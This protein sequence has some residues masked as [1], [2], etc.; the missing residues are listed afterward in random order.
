MD[1]SRLYAILD[2]D[3]DARRKLRETDK[4]I[5][6]CGM[7]KEQAD[8]AHEICILSATLKNPEAFKLVSDEVWKINQGRANQ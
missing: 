3:P 6:D 1:M 4:V 2:S 8:I 7:T 5:K